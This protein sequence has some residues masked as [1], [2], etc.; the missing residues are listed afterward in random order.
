MSST[1]NTYPFQ[2]GKMAPMTFAERLQSLVTPGKSERQ[3][4][5]SLGIS[6]TQFA[7]YV[8]GAQPTLKMLVQI[9]DALDL[10]LDELAGRV[11]DRVRKPLVVSVDG[12]FYVPVSAAR[13]AQVA[14]VS[15]GPAGRDVDL[16]EMEAL[17]GRQQG[18]RGP[19]SSSGRRP[20]Q[21]SQADA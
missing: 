20:P 15:P 12:E 9:A 5:A 8:K 18:A 3:V 19:R 13:A 6:H 1:V 2:H 4:A 7:R 17:A 16:A 21:G 11:P 14:G 10:S